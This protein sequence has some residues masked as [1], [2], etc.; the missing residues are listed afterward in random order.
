[1]IMAGNKTFGMK[2]D[3]KE[4]FMS[5]IVCIELRNLFT[6]SADKGKVRSSRYKDKIYTSDELSGLLNLAIVGLKNLLKRG[7]YDHDKVEDAELWLKY[8]TAINEAEQFIEDK[9]EYS[10]N[11]NCIL[12]K[13]EV[14]EQ[15]KVW[16]KSRNLPI[17]DM[18]S[19]NTLSH[20]VQ[21]FFGEQIK[22]IWLDDADES[23]SKGRRVRKPHW[24]YLTYR[25][26]MIG[27]A[28]VVDSNDIIKYDLPTQWKP[29]ST[30]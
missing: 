25:V 3:V 18:I 28:Q 11:P 10:S 22:T 13:E 8:E 9:L 16:Y 7:H 6:E 19:P 14:Y 4:D 30:K 5:R 20:N 24:R 29:E 21:M 26:T 17:D 12:D 2:I 15:Y 1:M 23:E 27:N